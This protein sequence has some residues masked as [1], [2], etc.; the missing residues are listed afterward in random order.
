MGH[1][2]IEWDLTTIA[3]EER[4]ELRAWI[5]LHKRFRGLL[6]SGRVVRADSVARRLQLDGVVA[7]D[8][9]EALFRLSSLDL[10]LGQPAGRVRFP[11]LTPETAYRV[12]P[13]PLSVSP[14]DRPAPLGTTAC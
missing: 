7:P 10:T 1:L 5:A 8:G 14:K 9:R 11:G 2:G 3:D 13:V 6:H 12:T 4:E